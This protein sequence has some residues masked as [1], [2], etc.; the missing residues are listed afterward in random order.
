M[1][2]PLVLEQLLNGV[3]FGLMLFMISAGLTLT[4]GIVNFINLT[5]SSFY[6]LGA[7]MAASLYGLVGN[8]FVAVVIAVPCTLVL[9]IVI[10]RLVFRHLYR[11]SHLD[12]VLGTFALL[13]FFNDLMTVIYGPE[14][15]FI[16][17]PP[18]LAG[19]IHVAGDW[20]YPAYRLAITAVGLVMAALLWFVIVRTR[21]GMLIRAGAERP[22]TL[23]GLG[24]NVSTLFSLVFGMGAALAG[25]A[26]MITGPL[27]SVQAGMGDELLIVAFVVIVIGGIGSVRGA[28]LAAILVGVVDTMGRF[29]LPKFLGFDVGPAVASM[30][31]YLMMAA[32]LIFR[33]PAVR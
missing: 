15:R 17:M 10:D 14:P 24:V 12:Q 1:D 31:I 28:F 23:S 8:F 22:E 16:P 21:L 6:M 29:L 9:G 27:V 2:A 25:L 4:F 19:A 7:F 32:F 5:H 11:R 26:G 18:S 3:Q 20:S 13:A 30:A 33:P